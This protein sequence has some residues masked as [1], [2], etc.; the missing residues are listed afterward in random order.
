MSKPWAPLLL[1]ALAGGA[2]WA[3]RDHAAVAVPYYRPAQ[4]VAGLYQHTLLPQA[5]AFE[6]EAAAL[7]RE[8][9]AWCQASPAQPLAV[10]QTPWRRTLAAWE[11][12][13]TPALGPVLA[14]RS[15]RQIDF[16]PTRPALIQRAIARAPAGAAAL[17]QVGTPAKGLPALEW[18]LFQQP[19]QPATPACAYASELA[20][21]V[22][23]EAG[24]L[25]QAYGQRA[26]QEW[27]EADGDPA[28]A[29]L[30][31]QWIGGLERLRWA[32]MDK[33]AR[34]AA[35]TG[36]PP[37]WPRAASGETAASWARQWQA[38]RTLAVFA[39]GGSAPA[40]GAGAVPLETYLRGRG[41]N[42]LADRWRA[43][44]QRADRAM[45]GL[46]PGD[47]QRWAAAVQELARTKALAE[48]E[49]APALAISLGFS[50]ADGD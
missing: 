40:P 4:V 48:A 28:F 21:D 7:G 5:Q 50:D 37:A 34:E 15:P 1:L 38:L 13:S 46:R 17:E 26:A 8:L 44:V 36:K 10:V 47:R 12:L 30:L 23:R 45:Q 42:P 6:R 43:Q 35:T 14:R 25:A 18:L 19:L 27:E 11:Q 9:A 39:D 32:Q 29:E 33:P 22:A 41:L 24:A 31:N 16:T 20:A 2:A 49:L 3:Q